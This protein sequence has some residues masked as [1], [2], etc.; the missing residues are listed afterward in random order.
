[1]TRSILV[2]LIFLI[3]SF[4]FLVLLRIFTG[5][6]PIKIEIYKTEN[7]YNNTPYEYYRNEN[8]SDS[9]K[10]FRQYQNLNSKPEL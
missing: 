5:E 6:L 3:L 8:D 1:M 2:Y 4:I 9:T 10:I 7:F